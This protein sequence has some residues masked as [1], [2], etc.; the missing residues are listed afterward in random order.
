[1]T[2][3]RTRTLTLA[4]SLVGLPALANGSTVTGVVAARDGHSIAGARVAIYAPEGLRDERR[5]LAA[6][7]ERVALD[8]AVV[9]AGGIFHLKVPSERIVELVILHPERAPYA[10]TTYSGRD[11]GGIFLSPAAPRQGRVAIDGKPAAG[12][13]V[14]W[15]NREGRPLWVRTTDSEGRYQVPEPAGWAG[16]VAVLH[17]DAAVLRIGGTSGLENMHSRTGLAWPSRLEVDLELVPGSP[18]EGRVQDAGGIGI[19]DAEIV[20]DGWPVTTS[21]PDGRFTVRLG[22]D[23]APVEVRAGARAVFEPSAGA[24]LIFE[25]GP[26]RKL[27]A[28]VVDRDSGLPI[29]GASLIVI[30][31][32]WM[33]DRLVTDDRGRAEVDAWSVGQLSVMATIPDQEAGAVYQEL[34]W[35]REIVEARF[36]VTRTPTVT[37]RAVALAGQVVDERGEPIAG[38]YLNLE[39]NRARA[40]TGPDGTFHF[41]D[42]AAGPY[43]IHVSSNEVVP[44]PPIR[45]EAP[46]SNLVLE[47]S[48]GETLEGFVLD[49]DTLAPIEGAGI[50]VEPVGTNAPTAANRWTS[51]G[52]DGAF[53]VVG[54]VPGQVKVTA[55]AQGYVTGRPTEWTVEAGVGTRGV[56]IELERGATITGRVLDPDGEPVERVWIATRVPGE[57]IGPRGS[58]ATSDA[59]GRFELNGL[60]DG[61]HEAKFQ[62]EGYVPAVRRL[63]VERDAAP[64]ELEVVLDRGFELRGDVR[65]AGGQPL[66]GV[67]LRAILEPS[68]SPDAPPADDVA[69]ESDDD[70]AFHL[71]GLA[72]GTWTLHASLAGY[73]SE[74]VE[75]LTP[76]RAGRV[77]IVLRRLPTGSVSGQILAPETV[78]SMWVTVRGAQGEAGKGTPVDGRFRIEEVPVG[79][80]SVELFA[81][82]RAGSRTLKKPATVAENQETPV[83]FDLR[84]SI[85]IGGRVELDGSPLMDASLHF[86]ER[87]SANRAEATTDA[88]GAYRI[89][90]E[91][92]VHEITVRRPDNTL[93]LRTL[94]LRHSRRLDLDVTGG[95]LSGRVLDGGSGEP[96]PEASVELMPAK[97]RD[98]LQPSL[99]STRTDGSGR[100]RLVRAPAGPHLLRVGHAD[101][102]RRLVDIDLESGQAR[103]LD[104]ALEPTAGLLVRLAGAATAESLSGPIVVRDGRDAIIWDGDVSRDG[105]RLPLPPGDYKV[106]VSAG[107]YASRTVAASVPSEELVIPLTPGGSVRVLSATPE[108]RV[109]RLIDPAGEEY[110]RCWCN[111]ISA[112]RIAG[113]ETLIR[114]VAPGVYTFVVEEADGTESVYPLEVHEGGE[115]ELAVR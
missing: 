54:L 9:T 74:R 97:R 19:G 85:E 110:V 68:A 48:R 33:I 34:T 98:G 28:E 7:K 102:A 45:V 29:A 70:G 15:M 25:V 12:A 73:G 1:M 43:L 91:P 50:G 114:H 36:E 31:D 10:V 86:V 52:L 20:V 113:D 56:E 93:D 26:P 4:I 72:R 41:G 3:N 87:V 35:R 75:G 22:A 84:T 115:I 95:T 37:G 77:E 100:Y 108:R 30:A 11:L 39:D 14:I 65:D 2:S 40:K 88:D 13:R 76:A 32:K 6:G 5:R 53:K 8:A 62:V 17:P 99:P 64:A 61:E 106:S 71:A 96:V 104:V 57:K 79:D 82:S 44:S 38:V 49:R 59:E 60:P 23:A 92:G 80:V 69:G 55:R 89:E 63:R 47:L 78:T 51:S 21:R 16:A 94:E 58:S 112:F 66:A 90:L 83:D 81:S 46:D 111:Q 24:D 105:V 103:Q 107:G 27:K 67:R 109:A 18:R 101:Y 42:L